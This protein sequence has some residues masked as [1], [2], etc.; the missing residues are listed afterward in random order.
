MGWGLLEGKGCVCVSK[1]SI[2]EPFLRLN[3]GLNL[4]SYLERTPG[5]PREKVLGILDSPLW[6][7]WVGF[8][9][10]SCLGVL[11]SELAFR[12]ESKIGGLSLNPLR[13]S[14]NALHRYRQ[15]KAKASPLSFSMYF[16]HSSLAL[17][18]C[19]LR[20]NMKL[21]EFNPD[22]KNTGFGS[23]KKLTFLCI[24]LLKVTVVVLVQRNFHLI[25]WL[26]KKYVTYKYVR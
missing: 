8:L 3:D 25:A 17:R 14:M 12:C 20:R 11:C 26:S 5:L 15:G 2:P 10:P 24:H 7:P 22:Y 19:Q 23:W 9:C 21:L 16:L 4:W 13:L 6:A 1:F 18:S